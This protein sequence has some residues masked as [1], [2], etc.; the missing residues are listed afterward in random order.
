MCMSIARRIRSFYAAT[1]LERRLFAA[2]YILTP[3]FRAALLFIP[4]RRILSWQGA[5]GVESPDAP[6]PASRAYREAL[7]RALSLSARYW[8]GIASCYALCLT[9]KCLLRRNRLPSTMYIGFRKLP[10]G[11]HE[12]HA[13]LRSHDTWVTGGGKRHLYAVHS[14]YT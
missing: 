3:I 5:P 4:F 12:G 13:W 9:G 6:E 7:H 1:P 8:P 11:S 10:D 2:A 14:Q